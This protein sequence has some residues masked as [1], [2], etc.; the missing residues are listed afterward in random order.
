MA[1]EKYFKHIIVKS[2]DSHAP[3]SHDLLYL[4]GLAKIQLEPDQQEFL[5]SVNKFNIQGRYP[6]EKMEFHK[7]ATAKYAAAW[8]GKINKF[9]SWLTKR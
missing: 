9:Y 4:A 5:A 7:T 2:T 8:L 3:H 1:L 6:E